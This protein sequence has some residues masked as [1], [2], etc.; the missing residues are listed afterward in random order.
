MAN[1]YGKV[2]T[3]SLKERE[4]FAD[5]K[6]SHEK[7][8]E[9][10]FSLFEHAPV[11][12]YYYNEALELQ[13]VNLQFMQM[14]KVKNKEK[15]MGIGLKDYIDDTRII[16][17]HENAF[18]GQTGNYRGPYQVLLGEQGDIYVDL[19]TVPMFNSAG[20]I[21]VDITIVNDITSEVT[22][23]EK[24][25]RS[26]YYDMLTN[27][28]NRTLL[29]DK[30]K[31]LIETRKAMDEMSGLLFLDIDNFK[32]INTSFGHDIGDRVLKLAARKIEK[33]VGTHDALARIGGDKFVILIPDVG[34]EEGDAQLFI[35]RYITAI[36]QNFLQPLKVAGKE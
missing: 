36:N 2:I 33:A 15:L 8:K 35:T 26:A 7:L 13:D 17:V 22:A 24:K 3:G 25:M 9:R 11:G 32:K 16:E 14:N 18:R 29:M 5:I 20:E 1:Y 19:S 27:I 34:T 21:A 30:L 28:P 23:Q 12:I 10:F 4:Q 31:T 6:A